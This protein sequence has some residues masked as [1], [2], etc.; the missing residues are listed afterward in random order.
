MDAGPNE[1]KKPNRGNRSRAGSM[2]REPL[3]TTLANAPAPLHPPAPLSAPARTDTKLVLFPTM[4]E[5]QTALSAPVVDHGIDSS[6]D[7]D[8]HLS[9]IKHVKELR[10]NRRIQSGQDSML[11]DA[12]PGSSFAS[13][14]PQGSVVALHGN[15]FVDGHS[16]SFSQTTDSRHSAMSSSTPT[17]FVGTPPPVGMPVVLGEDPRHVDLP[18]PAILRVLVDAYFANVYSQTYA[19]LHRPTFMAN[20]EKH[21]PVLL[22]SMCAVAARFSSYRSWE[23]HFAARAR[24]LIMENYDKYSLDV[25]QSLVH[26]G[27]HDFGSSNGHKAWMFAG[28]AVRMGAALNMNLENRKR[29]KEKSTV[30][31][32]CARRTYWSYYLMDVSTARFQVFDGTLISC[33]RDSTATASHDRSSR[34]IMIATYSCL[35]TS[36]LSSVDDTLSLSISSDP[37]RTIRIVALSLWVQWPTSYAWSAYGGIS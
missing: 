15:G 24:D 1:N 29:D 25:V 3:N 6:M 2:M 27:L 34:K 32:E 16:R 19:F 13:A 14:S 7:H 36:L 26:M 17:T 30:S 8:A 9:R 21:T 37:I 20:M 4:E 22:F 31:K 18:N 23:E 5:D 10:V 28:M 11:P 35:A 12:S 33:G